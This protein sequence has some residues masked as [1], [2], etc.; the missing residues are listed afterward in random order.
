L[1]EA[2]KSLVAVALPCP[3]RR[4][5]RA[6]G[7]AILGIGLAF[8]PVPSLANVTYSYLG[9]LFTSVASNPPA[10]T[11]ITGTVAFA[12]VLAPNASYTTADALAF[13]FSDGVS[14]ID[15]TNDQAGTFLFFGTDATGRITTWSL[16]VIRTY[17]N[18]L[19]Q[20]RIIS[21]YRP[22]IS[23]TLDSTERINFGTGIYFAST[24]SPTGVW[25]LVPE[26]GSAAM[27][28][29]GLWTLVLLRRP[30]LAR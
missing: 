7:A 28:A 2:M 27:L 19:H 10:P 30:R 14:T 3:A 4:S 18:D 24:T 5:R 15:D 22:A 12:D 26:P 1:E 21:N 16:T 20:V 11:R 9:P 29:A 17:P 23:A 25:T 6:I 13:S 8:G